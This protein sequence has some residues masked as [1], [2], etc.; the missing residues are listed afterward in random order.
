MGRF[1][2][3]SSGQPRRQRIVLAASSGSLSVPVWAQG[4]KGVA[5]VSG[6]GGG[7]ASGDASNFGGGGSGALAD[8]FQIVIPS[9]ITT[10]QGTIAAGG[11]VV[12]GSAGNAGGN[13]VFRLGAVDVLTLNGGQ[14]GNISAGSGGIGGDPRINGVTAIVHNAMGGASASNVQDL[15]RLRQ[16]LLN[17]RLGALARGFSGR[18]TTTSTGS[19]PAN[20]WNSSDDNGAP[21][22]FGAAGYGYG[23]GGSS[24]A[25]AGGPG[26]LIVEFVEAL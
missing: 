5:L 13:T 12:G 19:L 8:N 23:Y 15:D 3:G 21:S 10:F 11:T 26:I 2:S 20:P 22:W 7:G 9:G 16:D 25:Q 17:F 14:G 18:R 6:A 24:R 1:I 4:G